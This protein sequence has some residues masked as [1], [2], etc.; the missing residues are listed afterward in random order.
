MK[1]IKYLALVLIVAIVLAG[2][3]YAAWTDTIVINTTASTGSMDVQFVADKT[4]AELWLWDAEEEDF[5][6]VEEGLALTVRDKSIQVNVDDMYP[7]LEMGLNFRMQNFGSIPVV[8]ENVVVDF[9]P[10]STEALKNS[11]GI[12]WFYLEVYGADGKF[13]ENALEFYDEENPILLADLQTFLNTELP[14]KLELEPGD[15]VTLK[16][17]SS[18]GNYF[19]K[20]LEDAGNDTQRANLD[21][22]ISFDWKQFNK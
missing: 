3:A 10:N 15:Y 18:E 14:G 2:V 7:G 21:M 6:E 5:V 12:L 20:F 13:K 11:M 16:G 17:G 1:K 19:L 22:T 9:G 8:C 4:Y